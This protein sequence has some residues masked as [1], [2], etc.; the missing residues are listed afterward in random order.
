MKMKREN[1]NLFIFSLIFKKREGKGK[2]ERENNK[3]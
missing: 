3:T 1:N 2:R